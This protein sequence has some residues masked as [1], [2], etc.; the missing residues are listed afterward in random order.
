MRD[1]LATLLE[2]FRRHGRQ[3][4]V[5][6]HVG[7]RRLATS[8]AELA[9]LSARFA[10][11]LTR[12]GIQPG[13]R[14]LL[15]GQNR[16]EWIAAFF[17]CVLRGVIA[18]PLD[19]AGGIGFA[20]RVW[21]ETTPSLLTGNQALLQQLNEADANTP[22]L[23]F[24]DFKER[25]PAPDYSPLAGLQRSTPLQ[26]IFT[27]GTTA[28]PRGIVHTHGN[29]LAS[30]D[31]IEQE[32]A[33]YLKYERL[34][35]PLRFLHTLPLS[36]VFGQFMGLWIPPLL[37]AQVHF[38]TRLEAPR[39]LSLVRRERISV[40]AAVPRVLELL[41]THLLHLDASLAKR[42]AN[43]AGLPALQRWWRFR[44]QH[45]LF[46]WKFWAVVCG[47]ATLPE[48]LEE[49]WTG[50]GFALIQGYGMTETT[51][52]VTLNHPFHSTRG[53]IGKPLAGRE[54]RLGADGEILVRGGSIASTEW[55]QGKLQRRETE[56]GWLAT[57]DLA[58][59]GKDG[60][61]VF[62]GRK[63]ETIVT[64]AGLNIYP[65]D[66]EAA[67]LRFPGV[68]G[69]LVV[70]HDSA[71]GPQPVAVLLL[72]PGGSR[73]TADQ[74]VAQANATLA[75]YQ[76]VRRW[77]V[78]PQTDFPRTTTGKVLRRQVA[79]WAEGALKS[80]NAS[81]A[82]EHDP[83][84]R[85]LRSIPGIAAEGSITDDCRLNE[86]LHL[87]SL[88]LVELQST[89]ESQFGVELD[90][91]AFQQARTVGDL[92]L[93]LSLPAVQ[94][95]QG[96]A[97]P[98]VVSHL[99]EIAR[100][101]GGEYPR[102]PWSAPV[103]WVRN[104]F[105]GAVARPLVRFLLHPHVVRGAAAAKALQHPLLIVS[106][107]VTTFDVPLVLYALPRQARNRVAVAT[108]GRML[109]G[110]RHAQAEQYR[111]LSFIT[112]LAYWVLTALF[113]LFP[114]P[115]GPGFRAS[116]AHAG[117]ALDRGMH[118]LVFPEGRR[119]PDGTLAAFQSGVGLLAQQ[120][121]TPVLPVAL[122]G[123][124]EIK[125]R[126]RRWFRPGTVTIHMGDPV[127]MLV[128]ETPQ[129]FSERLQSAVATLG[130]ISNPATPRLLSQSTT[131]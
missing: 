8:W 99:R 119:S 83:L 75:P 77:L 63:S 54:V 39:L 71:A 11:E 81:A 42:L 125:Q 34:V 14:V 76:Q 38:E 52:L 7:N 93:L 25:L 65:Q 51:A 56:D 106:N 22:A 126:K 92:R 47:G 58:A 53:S 114:L 66:I 112:P 9:A 96:A 111:W 68:Q 67:L 37:G 55:R 41:R 127:T 107:H 90:E 120:S 117:E 84:L 33:R 78:W 40:L 108:A 19:A 20:E 121:G 49:F 101:R 31:P 48:S 85:A 61:L 18:V 46:G 89:L 87:D 86:D 123:L 50:L 26:I 16:A 73:E 35:H 95:Q 17:G 24:E 4:A 115:Q 103:R 124:G 62:S 70:G 44:R 131:R 102:W 10:A 129:A 13:D 116:F 88:G 128:N 98:T 130:D 72:A 109:L 23:P 45:R 3:T 32:M 118:V 69:A 97:A 100:T 30:L 6:T 57:G 74:A 5:V 12:R 15:W 60:A 28:E 36:H 104:L 2:D 1:H 43:S 113:N 105:L 80:G 82:P 122:E 91:L 94:E 27:S 59:A 21:R 29:V 64:A 110:W 79:V